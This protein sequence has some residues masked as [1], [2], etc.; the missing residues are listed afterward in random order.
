MAKLARQIELQERVHFFERAPLIYTSLILYFRPVAKRIQEIK[1]RH[2]NVLRRG[3]AR[4]TAS[5]FE[6]PQFINNSKRAIY[7]IFDRLLPCDS[8]STLNGCRS[9]VRNKQ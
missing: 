1:V 5:C 3:Q 9:V 8:F 2:F 4:K 6:V 7:S